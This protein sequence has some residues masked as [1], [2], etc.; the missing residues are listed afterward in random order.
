MITTWVGRFQVMATLQAVRA[1]T[2][3]LPLGSAKSWGLNRAIYYA[4]AKRGFKGTGG[5]GPARPRGTRA[6]VR[7]FHLGDD[8][9]YYVTAGGKRLFTIGGDLQKPEDFRRQIERRFGGTFRE[10]WGEALRIVRQFPKQVLESPGA[11]YALVYRPRRDQLAATWN[12]R[13]AGHRGAS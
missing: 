2:L 7:E 10:A 11:F 13:A 9:A 4:A 8:K 3:G 6:T 1:K 5:A 12:E